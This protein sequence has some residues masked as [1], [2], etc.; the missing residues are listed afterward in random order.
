MSKSLGK[1]PGLASQRISPFVPRPSSALSERTGKSL[2]ESHDGELLISYNGDMVFVKDDTSGEK[3]V[4]VLSVPC[5]S[6]YMMNSISKRVQY[7]EERILQMETAVESQIQPKRVHSVASACQDVSV[8]CGRV[9]CDTEGGRLNA[10]SVILEGSIATSRGARVRLDLQSCEEYQLFPGQIIAVIGKNPT[11]FCIVA[12]EILHTLPSIDKRFGGKPFSMVV[13][14]GP[15]TPSDS[16][17][18]EPLEALIKYCEKE[19]PDILMLVG[20]FVDQDHPEVSSGMLDVTFEDVFSIKVVE[21][22]RKLQE[23]SSIKVAMM[24]SIRD[25]HHDVAFP[26]GPMPIREGSGIDSLPN[27][28][29]IKFSGTVLGCSSVDWL[30]SAAK[31]EI[32]KSSKPVD[33]LSSLASLVLK[34]RSYYPLYPSASNVGLDVSS[35]ESLDIVCI[36]DILITPSDLAPFAKNTPIDISKVDLE[37]S[38]ALSV[39]TRHDVICINPGRVTKGAT[40]GTFAHIFVNE[41]LVTEDSISTRCKVEVR[42]L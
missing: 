33:R 39:S 36:P 37:N 29:T 13:A 17:M 38:N 10:Q 20:P 7:L 30:M 9:C 22:I 24:P 14:C 15:F 12:Q 1:T 25:V 41:E 8:F 26:Q 18:Y 11:G 5:K 31:E 3:S 4:E 19:N 21:E 34:Q 6:T 40:A 23:R 27:P 2:F 42:K 32:S 16:L 35:S 28:A